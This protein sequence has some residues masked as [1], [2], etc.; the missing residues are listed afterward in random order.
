MSAL[1]GERSGWLLVEATRC[2]DRMEIA[3][4]GTEGRARQAVS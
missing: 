1:P 4:A 3:G 2:S